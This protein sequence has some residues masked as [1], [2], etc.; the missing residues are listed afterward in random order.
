MNHGRSGASRDTGTGAIVSR[1]LVMAGHRGGLRGR[2]WV[3]HRHLDDVARAR[4][5]SR[6]PELHTRATYRNLLL[7]GLAPDE[8]ANLTAY[9]AGITV[10]E[11]HWTLRQINQLL[12]LREMDRTGQFAEPVDGKLGAAPALTAGRAG[13]LPTLLP[14]RRTLLPASTAF[15][16]KRRLPSSR[17][18][19]GTSGGSPRPCRPLPSAG[20]PARSS[21]S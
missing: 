6:A 16:P 20:W 1:R 5:R 13:L 17:R 14:W 3:G 4:S 11:T 12:F 10:G 9:L 21:A 7:R 18:R 15:R 2:V 8:A 19:F